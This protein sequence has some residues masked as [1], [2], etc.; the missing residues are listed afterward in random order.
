MQAVPLV[1]DL[2]MKDRQKALLK[3]SMKNAKK[4]LQKF[5]MSLQM[6]RGNMKKGEKE[7]EQILGEN[8]P[9]VFP[10][11][12]QLE[13]NH[14]VKNPR[15]I[16]L[17][18]GEIVLTRVEQE[19]M[20][21]DRRS[22]VVPVEAL[23]KLAEA[24]KDKTFGVTS[25]FGG[26]LEGEAL[27][28]VK[29]Y[30]GM[31]QYERGQRTLQR[32]GAW[33]PHYQESS[34]PKW[35]YPG[36]YE[37]DD[38]VIKPKKFTP[39]FEKQTPRHGKTS[40]EFKEERMKVAA[41]NQEYFRRV[42]ERSG[43]FVEEP[44][45]ATPSVCSRPHSNDEQSLMSVTSPWSVVS[46]ESTMDLVDPSS[47]GK[48]PSNINM[49]RRLSKDM[50]KAKVQPGFEDE[51]SQRD[52]VRHMNRYYHQ[53][54][55]GTAIAILAERDGRGPGFKRPV[56]YTHGALSLQR[57]V[58]AYDDGT[59]F[60][61]NSGPS[62]TSKGSK[63]SEYGKCSKDAKG[64]MRPGTPTMEDVLKANTEANAKGEG[65]GSSVVVSVEGEEG[66]GSLRAGMRKT[67]DDYSLPGIDLQVDTDELSG[68]I[69]T[70]KKDAGVYLPLHPKLSPHFARP[71]PVEEGGGKHKT[72]PNFPSYL[73]M[74]EKESHV[75]ENVIS[76][77]DA[78]EPQLTAR[79]DVDPEMEAKILE[80]EH[81]SQEL[82]GEFSEW[83][84]VIATNNATRLLLEM[85]AGMSMF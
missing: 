4:K 39:N 23:A 83:E 75:D 8:R 15:P 36:Y 33:F 32:K 82:E 20:E 28:T 17:S 56:D 63:D 27:R 12:K 51:L 50:L 43:K 31:N 24:R 13:R 85:G 57:D 48:S 41:A 65:D 45:Y 18:T 71:V 70:W 49:R 53:P 6:N 79:T 14:K 59:A 47:R 7:L 19:E 64:D 74:T 38:E 54:N 1:R 3:M 16:R 29:N 68:Y 5:E 42:Q 46:A 67:R 55:E 9:Q 40:E 72:M 44:R 78:Y 62:L 76:L 22:R 84:E 30:N 35:F 2:E 52:L 10:S 58:L 26:K 34:A 69:R 81:E 37:Y 60:T 61:V 21:K 77:S 11:L 25:Y 73:L 80:E 66:D